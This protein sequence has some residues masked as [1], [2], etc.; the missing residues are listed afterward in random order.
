M[1]YVQKYHLTSLYLQLLH[2][3]VILPL[4]PIY[5]LRKFDLPNPLIEF[6]SKFVRDQWTLAPTENYCFVFLFWHCFFILE[7]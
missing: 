2:M 6:Q 3:K 5:V 1:E 7:S 4:Q